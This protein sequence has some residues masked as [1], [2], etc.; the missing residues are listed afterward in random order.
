M[1]KEMLGEGVVVCDV[2]FRDVEFFYVVKD[3]LREMIMI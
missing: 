2:F 1:G 3:D